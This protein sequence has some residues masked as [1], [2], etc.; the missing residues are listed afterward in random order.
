MDL[1][2]NLVKAIKI[3]CEHEFD[4][5]MDELYTEQA[6]NMNVSNRIRQDEINLIRIRI[7]D[8]LNQI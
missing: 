6:E 2:A 4:K 8:K 1:S 3:I 7:R 5:R